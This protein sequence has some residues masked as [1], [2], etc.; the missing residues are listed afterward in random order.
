M[1]ISVKIFLLVI[2][3]II[4]GFSFFNSAEILLAPG[5]LQTASNKVCFKQNCFSVELAETEPER[6]RGLMY[7]KSLDEDRGMFF[8]FD[9]FSIA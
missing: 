3:I 2:A 6:E 1:K 7:Q 4:F 9:K 8:I 5:F